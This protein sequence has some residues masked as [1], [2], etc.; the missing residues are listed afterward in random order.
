VGVPPEPDPEIGIPGQEPRRHPQ[1]L[2]KRDLEIRLL[3]GKGDDGVTGRLDE[4]GV[5]RPGASLAGGEGVRLPEDSGA[6]PLRGLRPEKLG[7]VP[8]DEGAGLLVPRLHR[9]ADGNHRDRRPVPVGLFRAPV[10]EAGGRE[11]PDRVVNEK[12]RSFRRHGGEGV[13]DRVVALRPPLD[14]RDHFR[15]SPIRLG[16]LGRGVCREG[17]DDRVD[18]GGGGNRGERPVQEGPAADGE[19]L[20][21]HDGTHPAPRSASDD[22]DHRTD[23]HASGMDREPTDPGES[24][25]R[26]LVRNREEARCPTGSGTG[27]DPPRRPP[28]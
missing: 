15:E 18:A 20:L 16:H 10:E 9:V 5:V 22:D 11:R 4:G 25:P 21:W 28:P 27:E 12:D 24:G 17:E 7:P 19:K 3:P 8:R 6:E 2:G 26:Q 1:V 14:H 23:Q 13:A